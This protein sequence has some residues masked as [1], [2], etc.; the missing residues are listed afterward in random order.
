MTSKALQFLEQPLTL[1]KS[2]QPNISGVLNLR[3]N[4]SVFSFGATAHQWAMA[5]SFTSF[6]DHTHRRTTVGRTPLDEWSA[7]R[8][9]PDNTQHS[10][11]TNIHAF[12]RDSN[13]QSQQASGRRPTP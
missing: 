10:Q 12:A 2:P 3:H 6:L 13:P 11:E 7:R 8:P 4:Q 9:L 1:D 5:S